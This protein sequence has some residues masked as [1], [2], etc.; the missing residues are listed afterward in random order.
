MSSRLSA[1]RDQQ[2]GR[3]PCPG[4]RWASVSILL[5]RLPRDGLGF[6]EAH[7][8]PVGDL[9]L[10]TLHVPDQKTRTSAV[11]PFKKRIRKPSREYETGGCAARASGGP[12]GRPGHTAAAT[13][14]FMQQ[15]C[16]TINFASSSP[17]PHPVLPFIS[18]S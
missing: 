11:R 5:K 15:V 16:D 10:H 1:L 17:N 6:T 8:K 4:D 18:S 2:L 9:A 12:G 13:R 3:C 7:C 14:G